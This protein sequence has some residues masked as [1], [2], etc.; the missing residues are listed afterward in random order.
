[1]IPSPIPY[2]NLLRVGDEVLVTIDDR[3]AIVTRTPHPGSRTTQC[4]YVG[5]LTKA[6]YAV[7]LLR[8]VVP[9]E[10]RVEDCP[11]CDGVA[12]P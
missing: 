5:R 2:R 9:G 3:R 7:S 1:M 10:N 8:F 11:P 4:R 12:P 6:Y